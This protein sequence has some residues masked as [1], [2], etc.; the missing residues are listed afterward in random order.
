M[1]RSDVA[2]ASSVGL[3]VMGMSRTAASCGSPAQLPCNGTA[4]Y[5]LIMLN[6]YAC[7]GWPVLP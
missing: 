2:R 4:V 5:F 6:E 1:M 7:C 3:I